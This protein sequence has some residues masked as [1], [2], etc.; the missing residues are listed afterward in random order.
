MEQKTETDPPTSP[1]ESVESVIH[2]HRLQNLMRA[3]DKP[4]SNTE[5]VQSNGTPPLTLESVESDNTPPATN[6]IQ[7]QSERAI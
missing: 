7:I 5:S 4:A 2:P 3:D 6:V 1:P